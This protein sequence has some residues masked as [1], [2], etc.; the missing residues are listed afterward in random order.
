MPPGVVGE[1]RQ[2]APNGK[3]AMAPAVLASARRRGRHGPAAPRSVAPVAQRRE[4]DGR[5][6]ARGKILPRASELGAYLYCGPV[7]FVF[8][9][10]GRTEPVSWPPLLMQANSPGPTLVAVWFP[11]QVIGAAAAGVAAKATAPVAI[12]RANAAPSRSRF[13]ARSSR[14]DSVPGHRTGAPPP[15]GGVPYNPPQPSVSPAGRG[16]SSTET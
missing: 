12:V 10:L 8:P 11:L 4:R 15:Y 3:A 14:S 2:R 6:D 5:G 9:P 7:K 16:R 1:W 13:I